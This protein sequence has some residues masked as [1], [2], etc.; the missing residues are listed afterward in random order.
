MVVVG[1]VLLAAGG[2]TAVLAQVLPTAG[3]LG[4][5]G[6]GSVGAEADEGFTEPPVRASKGGVL[7]T[8]LEAR[9]GPTRIAGRSV[10]TRTFEGTVPGPTLRVRRGDRMRVAL[11]N[12]MDEPTNL[13]F[14]GLHV[15]PSGNSDNSFLHAM[16]GEKLDLVLDIP[17]DHPAGTFWYHPH[18]HGSVASQVFG[19]LAGAIVVEGDLDQ[20]PEVAAARERLLV[21]SDITLDGAGRIPA[22]GM[23]DAMNGREGE[24]VLVNGLFRPRLTLRPGETERWRLVNAGGARYYRLRLSGHSLLQI[25]T[26]GGALSEPVSVDELLLPPGRRAEVLIQAGL[27]GSYE[28]TSLPYDRGSMG[29]GMGGRRGSAAAGVPVALVTIVV[30]GDPAS[31]VLPRT[32][33]PLVPVPSAAGE[34]IAARR[35]IVLSESMGPGGMRFMIDGKLF[36]HDRVDTRV[37]LGTTEDWTIRNATD[38]DHP[39]HLHTNPFQV[40]ALNGQPV[41]PVGWEDTV[42]VPASRSVTLRV[43]FRDFAGKTMYHCHILDHEDRGM[44]GV[45]EMT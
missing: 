13:H 9:M 19:G 42:N 2:T 36:A 14:H 18:L 43:R 27:A 11:V 35:E 37:R 34:V 30:Q 20:V 1:G 39:F 29:M 7:E 12:H 8:V 45:V 26:D 28:L 15:S 17:T 6:T 31:G 21:F 4:F 25:A 41:R 38:M 24:L 44:M 32:L 23:M 22:A 16:P 5:G 10:T 33:A 3:R 40:V